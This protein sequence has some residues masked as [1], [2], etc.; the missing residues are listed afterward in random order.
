[1]S[2]GLPELHGW[3]PARACARKKGVSPST[4]RRKAAAG[5][6]D[7]IP[8]PIGPGAL[9]R[10]RHLETS[11]CMD[12]AEDS[13]TNGK[14]QPAVVLRDLS[15]LDRLTF[16]Q[17]QVSVTS[18]ARELGV[19]KG[20]AHRT[21]HRMEARGILRRVGETRPGPQGGRPRVIWTVA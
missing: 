3:L 21:L 6:Y 2:P 13:W 14:N 12:A 18:L 1:M 8:N 16:G 7:V 15:A 17:G 4:I 11:E 20:A 10:P 19:S 9:Y 5:V